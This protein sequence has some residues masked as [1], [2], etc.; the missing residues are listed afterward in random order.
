MCCFVLFFSANVWPLERKR[1]IRAVNNSRN[2]LK[3]LKRYRKVLVDVLE[4]M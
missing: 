4:R 1:L 3:V 2:R